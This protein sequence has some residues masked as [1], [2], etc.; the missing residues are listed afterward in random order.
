MSLYPS[1]DQPGYSV[2]LQRSRIP[3][4]P[5]YHYDGQNTTATQTVVVDTR[6]IHWLLV[7]AC[8][9]A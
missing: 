7:P 1:L 9:D 4:A 6:S 5:R 2:S 3:A 8:L